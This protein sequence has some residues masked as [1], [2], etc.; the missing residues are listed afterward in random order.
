MAL[1]AMAVLSKFKDVIGMGSK[2]F[3]CYSADRRKSF[4]GPVHQ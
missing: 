1:M 4:V 3:F 2:C